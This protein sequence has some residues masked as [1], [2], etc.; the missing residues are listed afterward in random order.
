M[1]DLVTL[2]KIL[3]YITQ[4]DEFFKNFQERIRMPDMDRPTKDMNR[5][6]VHCTVITTHQKLF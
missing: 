2:L 3:K 5:V 1:I 6:Q 4:R